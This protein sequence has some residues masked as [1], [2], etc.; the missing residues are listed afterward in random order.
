MSISFTL[1]DFIYV[2]ACI[3][4]LDLSLSSVSHKFGIILIVLPAIFPTVQKLYYCAMAGPSDVM[5]PEKFG[6]ENFKRWQTRVKF[7][8]MSMNLWWVISPTVERPL[9]QE[10]QRD[11]EVSSDTAMGCLLSLMTDQLCDIYLN[12][13]SPALVWEALDRK[14]GESDAGRELYVNELYHDFKM[15]DNNSVVTQAHEIQLLVGV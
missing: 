5:K 12:F 11:F 4:L 10:Q 14:Y 3:N 9:T 7:W 1:L 6:D 15:A 8:L 2:I 13:A